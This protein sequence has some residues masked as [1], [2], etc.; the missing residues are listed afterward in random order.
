MGYGMG[1]VGGAGQGC[2]PGYGGGYGAG[3]GAGGILV[4]FILLVIITRSVL[5]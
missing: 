4:L 2:G 5:F 1:N 3:F